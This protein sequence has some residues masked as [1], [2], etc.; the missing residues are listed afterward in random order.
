[1]HGHGAKPPAAQPI[2]HFAITARQ[3]AQDSHTMMSRSATAS[4][5]GRASS[6][7]RMRRRSQTVTRPYC[8]TN[9]CPSVLEMDPEMG[10]ARCAICGYVRT[11]N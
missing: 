10:N 5:T 3:K 8:G 2:A 6:I 1:M 11:I 7:R 9:G 4:M